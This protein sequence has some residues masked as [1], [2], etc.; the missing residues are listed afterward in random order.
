[1][2]YGILDDAAGGVF[3]NFYPLQ[4]YARPAGRTAAGRQSLLLADVQVP[5]IRFNN[6]YDMLG[7]IPCGRRLPD[8][9]ER[10]QGYAA[11]DHSFLFDGGGGGSDKGAA[12]DPR[13]DNCP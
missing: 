5:A 2:F 12:A 6:T 10:P 13:G 4:R 8:R 9:P 7:T 11:M 1:M 3:V